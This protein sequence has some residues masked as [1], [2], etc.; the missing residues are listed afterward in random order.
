MKYL[1]SPLF[2]LLGLACLS[3]Q[4][5]VGISGVE[6]ADKVKESIVN[7]ADQGI[8]LS[9]QLI[10][11]H[12]FIN[13]E[14]NSTIEISKGTDDGDIAINADYERPLQYTVSNIEGIILNRGKFVGRKNIPFVRLSEGR[15][16]VYLFAGTTVVKAFTVI[17]QLT[18]YAAF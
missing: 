18:P 14:F 7:P 12:G 2:Y 4:S 10:L 5:H 1:I 6:S 9:S 15:Y 11:S 13:S 17:K 16:V 8:V 3:G